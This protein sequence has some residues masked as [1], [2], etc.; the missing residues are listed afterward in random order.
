MIG[1]LKKRLEQRAAR[2]QA[3]EN[4]KRLREF[5]EFRLNVPLQEFIGYDSYLQS[6]ENRLWASV[7]AVHLISAAAVSATFKVIDKNSDSLTAVPIFP[8]DN[9]SEAFAKGSFFKKPNPL[10]TWEELIQLTIAHLE[11]TGNAFWV[12]DDVDGLGRPTAFFPL[13]PQNVKILP[14]PTN[15]VM[16]YLYNVNGRE[17]PFEPDQVIHFKYPHHGDMMFGLGAIEA[18]EQLY[19]RFMGKNDLEL[20]FIQNGAQPSGILTL[21][22][23]SVT[24]EEE[25]RKLKAKF[26]SEYGGTK[27]AGKTAFLN[28]KWT[29]HKLGL[30]M[31]EMQ[32]ITSEKWN[33]E[34][35]FL[36]HG[37]P[38]S[39]AGIQN[40]ANYA[41]ARMDEQNFRRYK[42]VPIIDLIVG[43]LNSDGF[44]AMVDPSY[45]I[46]YELYGV[47][48]VEQIVKAHGPLLRDGVITRNE[49]RE[50]LGLKRIESIPHMDQ[51]MVPSHQVPIELAGI[52][53]LPS[54]PP[55]LEPEDDPEDEPEDEPEDDDTPPNDPPPAPPKSAP[56]SNG[57]PAKKRRKK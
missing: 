20:K 5:I 52:L 42:V 38:L 7:R 51:I 41:T 35:I 33:I 1:Y 54:L 22:D 56:R 2:A 11:F 17:I 43:K 15:R 45:T 19:Q 55:P 36:N 40:A 6:A 32:A 13:L 10:D 23:A 46:V 18:G 31:E 28:G 26:N 4:E 47:V 24:D 48:D 25:W 14:D 39:I 16:R 27:N 53:N 21:D 9:P 49:F 29:Y 50:I 57:Y 37:V 30:T 3:I 44:M 34:Q 8:K 12:K